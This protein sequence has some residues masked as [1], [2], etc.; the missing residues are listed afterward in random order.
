MINNDA[1]ISAAGG[2]CLGAIFGDHEG[3]KV[4]SFIKFLLAEYEV[5]VVEALAWKEALVL[6]QS[7]GL[8]KVILETDNA[9]IF[10]KLQASKSDFSYLGSLQN[11]NTNNL[12][13][14]FAHNAVNPPQLLPNGQLNVSSLVQNVNQLLQMQMTNCGPQNLGPFAN[15]RMGLANGNG[16]VP[17]SVDGNAPKHLKD[18]AAVTKDFGSPQTQRNQNG[19]SPGAAKSQSNAGVVNGDNDRKNSW[20]KS[21][22]K[23]FIGNHKQ[24]ASQ[25]GSL[26]LNYTEQEIQ[27]WREARRKNYPSNANMEKKSKE[28]PTQAEVMDAVAKMRR[29]QLKEILAK[30]AELGC[31]V[32]EVP[33]YYLSDSELQTDSRQQ[34]YKEFGKREN[35]HKKFDKKGKF[36]QIDRFPK[37]QRPDNS[38]SANLQN[39]SNR[40]N[41]KQRMANGCTTNP[42]TDNK[43]EPSLLKK[44]LSCDIKRDKR[45]LLQVFR[46]MVMNSFF[47][48]WPEKSLKFP[49][50]IVK[51]SG[52]ENAILEEK[53]QVVKGDASDGLNS[54]TV[55]NY[56]VDDSCSAL[57][58]NVAS[59]SIAYAVAEDEVER[60]QEDGEIMD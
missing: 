1:S 29:Q 28:N 33:S 7:M 48:N 21:H 13:Q 32:A 54:A 10:N 20:R 40:F 58:K 36:H 44:L 8:H 56:T 51:E 59:C 25:R 12:S 50:V 2:T 11:L 24:D 26:V 19:F 17:Q 47:E 46:F 37:R 52:D 27:Q 16:V 9:T 23:N 31:E 49:E 35:F 42:Q 55:E 5:V 18:N 41:K 53:P 45:H 34:N 15:A 60:S 3:R 4:N 22:N 43:R 14:L 57:G 6:A 38:N 30:Q 39:Q